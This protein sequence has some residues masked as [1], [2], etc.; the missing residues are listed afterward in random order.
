MLRNSALLA[1]LTLAASALRLPGAPSDPPEALAHEWQSIEGGHWQ[2]VSADPEEAPEDTDRTENTRGACGAGMVEVA[3]RMLAPGSGEFDAV[4]ALQRGACVDWISRTFPERCARFDPAR[5]TAS[6]A[7]LPRRMMHFCV[8]RFEYPNLRGAYPWIMVDWNAAR[9]LCGDEGKR[10]CSE[11]EWTFACEGEDARPYPYG[12][13][14]DPEACVIDRPWRAYDANAL[15]SGDPGRV[16]AELDRLW[17]GQPSGARPRCRSPFGVYDMTGNVDEW[18]ASTVG[19]E[20]PSVLKGGYWGP[21]R[22]RCRPSTRAHGATFTFYQQGFRCCTDPPP[23]AAP[24][25]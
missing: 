21:V 4:G 12:Y 19:G 18:T 10:L 13:E 5:W 6:A 15:G 16:R 2:I 24:T 17:Q 7:S 8:D 25:D 14:R 9:A 22:A 3:G 23:Q 11:D 1:L 20:R